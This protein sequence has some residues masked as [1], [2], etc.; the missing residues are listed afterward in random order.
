MRP[1]PLAGDWDGLV[2]V[3]AGTP[4]DGVPF[5]EHHL[6][7]RLARGYA[8]V[9]YVD[10]PT[11]YLTARR[12]PEYAASLEGPRLRLVEPGLARLT[13][14]VL[15]GVERP[16]I[17]TTT[18]ALVRRAMRRATRALGGRVAAVVLASQ[19]DLF[20]ACAERRRIVYATDDLVAGAELLG[21][22]S[23]RLRA[24]AQRQACHADLV[25]GV[26]E[27]ICDTWRSF[28]AP[29][30]LVPNGVDTDLFADVD[31]APGA[32]DVDLPSPIAGFVGH[33]SERI[34]IALLDAV[35]ATGVSLLLVG[36][37]QN[38]FDLARLDPVL[39]RPNVRWVGPKAFAELP[40]YLRLIDVGLTPYADT[41]FNRASFPLKTLEYL[42]AGRAAVATDLPAVRWLGTDLVTVASSP[43][44]YA[45]AA[46]AELARPHSPSLAAARRAFAR[47]HSWDERAQRFAA[48]LGVTERSGG[49]TRVAM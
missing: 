9:L 26:S 21:G 35:A 1:R 6:A 25:V 48:L 5:P 12:H 30:E 46:L 4:W 27:V 40:S 45:G 13:P 7:E 16:V 15:P 38:T 44:A 17:R 11:S 3:C 36:P 39:R 14:V 32:S 24:Q 42:A 47:Q 28:G 41:A 49:P 22:D 37:R 8:P 18:E 43:R 19:H 33:L 10:P 29:T 23:S 34:D 2:V 31:A 20:G